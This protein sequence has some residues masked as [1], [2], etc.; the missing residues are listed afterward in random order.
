MD[1]ICIIIQCIC[2]LTKF[3][4]ISLASIIFEK[5]QINSPVAA[6][7]FDML[8]EY[9]YRVSM[10]SPLNRILSILIRGYSLTSC[11]Y[12]DNFNFRCTEH[13]FD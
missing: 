6:L 3:I 10:T 12:E 2:A 1:L 7:L 11:F 9:Y 8:S 5:Q 13:A 4:H